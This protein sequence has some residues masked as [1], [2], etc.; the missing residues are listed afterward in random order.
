[1]NGPILFGWL[2]AGFEWALQSSLGGT[3]V[4][5]VVFLLHLY[6]RK[7]MPARLSYFLWL[8]VLVRL[9][10]PIV[11]TSH[12]SVFNLL[13]AVDPNYKPHALSEPTVLQAPATNDRSVSR[14]KALLLRQDAQ[15]A[16]G[17]HTFALL[18]IAGVL[19]YLGFVLRQ[20]W[21]LHRA[22]AVQHPVASSRAFSMLTE[23]MKLFKISSK[24][25]LYDIAE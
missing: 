15:P 8:C 24:I 6:F 25:E 22:L 7:R 5:G 3:A 16:F 19:A 11:P 14:G 18:W 12:L 23:G 21:I 17:A 9:A 20:N 13:P 4:A 2:D 1:M 10:L